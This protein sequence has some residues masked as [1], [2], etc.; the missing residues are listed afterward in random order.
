MTQITLL[1]NLFVMDSEEDEELQQGSTG[2]PTA[3]VWPTHT[4]KEYILYRYADQSPCHLANWGFHM[5]TW[6]Y[7]T[8]G[9]IGNYGYMSDIYFFF[10]NKKNQ[11]AYSFLFFLKNLS[12]STRAYTILVPRNT[13]LWKQS[14]AVNWTNCQ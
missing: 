6:V 7:T 9:S 4:Y 3:P 14:S 2:L 11:S 1:L 8:H 10:L 5:W 12:I 13:S